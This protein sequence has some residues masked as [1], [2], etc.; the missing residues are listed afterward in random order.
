MA[1][2]PKDIKDRL[3]KCDEE[4]RKIVMEDRIDQLVQLWDPKYEN[5]IK[6][7]AH[8]K[9][10]IDTIYVIA[11]LYIQTSTTSLES[12]EALE[13]IDIRHKITSL[14]E[15]EIMSGEEVKFFVYLLEY[16]K[17]I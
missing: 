4:D 7:L 6:G 17:C 5:I 12:I 11:L 15:N 1:S 14:I 8:K 3:M 2:I 13:R 9:G 10:V 16:Y